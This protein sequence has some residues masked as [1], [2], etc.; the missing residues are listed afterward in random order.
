MNL[1]YR[2]LGTS[3]VRVRILVAALVLL[4]AGCSVL[5]WGSRSS[6]TAVNAA[7]AHHSAQLSAAPR[8]TGVTAPVPAAPHAD[9]SRALSLMAGLPLIFE[10]NQGQANLNISDR[11]AKFMTRGSGYSL[12]LGSEG[13]ILTLA[14]HEQQKHGSGDKNLT[15]DSARS[16]VESLQMKLAG[17][18]PNPSITGADLLP[19]MSNYFIG[20]DPARWRRGVP[21]FARVRYEN[22]YPGINLVFYGN[23]GRLEYDFQVAPGANPALAELEF[24]SAKNLSL[25]NGALLIQGES[26]SIQLESPRVYQEIAGRQEPV[27]ARFVIRGAHRAG[28][29]IGSYDHSREL[30]IDPI[31]VFSTYFGGSGNEQNSQIAVD[32]SFNIYLAGSTT[33][34]D[35]PATPGVYQPAINPTAGAQNVY[36][37]RI[38]PPQGSNPAILNYVTYL[39]G[40]GIDYPVGVRVDGAG[41]VYLAGT[42]TSTNF[43]VTATNAYQISAE[44]VGTH[45]FV[46]ELLNTAASLV[47]SSYLSGN[48]TDTASGMTI[49]ASGDIYITGSTT[50][51]DVSSGTDQ[52]PA[53][54]LPQGQPYQAL[55]RFP[56]QPQ[57]FVTKVNPQSFRTASILY[58]TYFGGGVAETT[59]IATGGGIAVDTN[60]IVYFTGTTNYIYTGTDSGSDF[61]ILNAYQPCLDVPPA[62]T[63]TNP[64]SCTIMSTQTETDAFVAKLNISNPNISPGQQLLWSTYLGGTGDD[65]GSGIALDTGAVHA[66]IVGTTDSYTAA[67]VTTLTNIAAYQQCLDTPVNPVIGTLACPVP[68]TTPYPTDAYVAVLDNPTATTGVDANVTLTYYSYLGGSLNDSGLAIAVDAASGAVVTGSTQSVDF[69]VAPAANPIQSTLQGAQNAF[70]ARLDTV[71]TTGANTASSWAN[72][73]GGNGTDEGTSVTLDVN[74]N[75]YFAGDTTSTSLFPLNEA[76]QTVNN[77]GVDAF[78]THLGPAYSLSIAGVLTQGTNQIYVDAGSQATFTYTITNNGPDLANNITVTDNLAPSATLVTLNLVSASSTSGTCGSASTLA[79]VSCSLPALQPGSTSTMTVVVTPQPSASP[80]PGGEGFNGGTVQATGPGNITPAT[81]VVN[82]TMSDFILN[83]SPSNGSVVQAG[84]SA[85]YNISLAPSPVYSHAIALGCTSLPVATTCNFSTPSVTL[86]G[87]GSSLLTVTTTARPVITTAASPLSNRFYAIW[88]AVPGLTLLGVGVGDGKRRRR[89]LGVMMFCA[90]F[91]MILLQ[92]SCSKSTSV[93][94]ASG[95]PSGNYNITV[96]ATSGSD[97]KSQVISLLVP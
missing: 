52:F 81:T 94:P 64:Q 36:V 42:T 89:I 69:P 19:G 14:S 12:F 67:P 90:L 75:A 54:N 97:V 82:A 77:G 85:Q 32:G 57:F 49:D 66:Y 61:P 38:Q 78:A 93:P 58:S 20:N 6:S 79:S 70:M 62:S 48:G 41:D 68:V 8:L 30:V 83:V 59:A 3:L 84:D 37:A 29:A 2:W 72:Y 27:E 28:F 71:G 40:S 86:N 11:R 80:S 55:S 51:T 35:L 46:T 33:S 15:G 92:P 53:S 31:L 76:L 5:E 44:T 16:R 43:P 95:T 65:S 63:I 17:A 13:A 87:P 22:I 39:G 18:N 45:A 96:T 34:P 9:G 24:N 4:G 10:P 74:Q 1:N 73:F 47:Y 60:G 7:A 91:A 56:G 88:L 50:S 21:Q 23:Q 25:Q 26:E